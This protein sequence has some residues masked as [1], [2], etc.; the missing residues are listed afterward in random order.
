MRGGALYSNAE[1]A[2]A[3]NNSNLKNR[4]GG[5]LANKTNFPIQTTEP[6]TD[7]LDTD[8][9]LNSKINSD[10]GILKLLFPAK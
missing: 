2:E 5:L 10:P 7:A 4:I 1:I 9:D 3:W 6:L 8:P